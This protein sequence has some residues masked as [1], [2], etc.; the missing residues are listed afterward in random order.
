MSASLLRS[1]LYVPANRPDLVAKTGRFAPD[2]VVIDLEDGTPEPHKAS[3]RS[4][5]AQAA[6]ELRRSYGGTI[7]LRVN[8]PASSWLA[9]DLATVP[10]GVFDGLVVPKVESAEHVGQIEAAMASRGER[11]PVMWGFETVL[12]VHRCHEVLAASDQG[13]AAYFGAEDYITDLGGRRTRGSAETL[14]ARTAVAVAARLHGLVALDQV[15]LDFADDDHFRMDAAAGRDLG[16]RGK[17][18]IHP[19]QVALCHEAFTPSAAAVERARRLLACYD[20][21]VAL[22]RGTADFEGQMIDTPLV[23]QAQAIIDLAAAGEGS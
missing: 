15:V 4:Q 11:L 13:I 3:A 2:A 17:N 6:R 7:W 5:A 8:A 23:R 10:V 1:S 20:A 9:E 12:G 18:C 19:A 21:A 14:A 22:G 16:Y